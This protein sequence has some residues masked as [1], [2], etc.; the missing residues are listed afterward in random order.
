MDVELHQ[1]LRHRLCTDDWKPAKDNSGL[2]LAPV[3]LFRDLRWD[4]LKGCIKPLD[5]LVPENRTGG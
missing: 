3:M 5:K 4:F 1:L 2:H